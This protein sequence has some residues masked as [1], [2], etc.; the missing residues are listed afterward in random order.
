MRSTNSIT[1][2]IV[3]AESRADLK[4]SRDAGGKGTKM[5]INEMRNHAEFDNYK[6]DIIAGSEGDED[7]HYYDDID[8]N[9]EKAETEIKYFQDWLTQKDDYKYCNR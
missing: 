6:S 4:R 9:D 7:R 2:G 8:T 5:T 3:R 1:P